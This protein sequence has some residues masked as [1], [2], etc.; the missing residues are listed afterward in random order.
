MNTDPERMVLPF[1]EFCKT[2]VAVRLWC[3]AAGR[4]MRCRAVENVAFPVIETHFSRRF[5]SDLQHPNALRS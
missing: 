1:K 5:Q 2:I 3:P 4:L